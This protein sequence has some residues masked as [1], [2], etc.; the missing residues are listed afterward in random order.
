MFF[1]IGRQVVMYGKSEDQHSLRE[2]RGIRDSK[3]FK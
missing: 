2:Y 3:C 1:L